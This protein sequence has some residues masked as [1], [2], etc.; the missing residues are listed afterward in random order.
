MA[1]DWP[2]IFVAHVLAVQ[3]E[4]CENVLM[5]MAHTRCVARFR[6]VAPAQL[7]TADT[8]AISV[9]ISPHQPGWCVVQADGQLG[10]AQAARPPLGKLELG[11]N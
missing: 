9:A 6:T 4:L 1:T 7:S 5:A 10:V 8:V 11:G 3:L 2:R